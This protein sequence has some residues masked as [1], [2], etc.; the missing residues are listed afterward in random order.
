VELFGDT[1]CCLKSFLQTV[2]AW[3]PDDVFLRRQESI[4]R[5]LIFGQIFIRKQTD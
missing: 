5:N 4:L 1:E 3:L 2:Y